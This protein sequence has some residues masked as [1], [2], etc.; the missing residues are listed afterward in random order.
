MTTVSAKLRRLQRQAEAEKWERLLD[1]QW[2]ALGYPEM[3][4]EYIVPGDPFLANKPFDRRLPDTTILIEIDGGTWMTTGY[5]RSGG[6]AHPLQIED[7][8]EKRNR[9]RLLGHTVYQFTGGQIE[10]G[11]AVRVLEAVVKSLRQKA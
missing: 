3:D 5:G 1:L 7:D 10:R 2:R 6:H 8:N 4:R 11:E 9:A